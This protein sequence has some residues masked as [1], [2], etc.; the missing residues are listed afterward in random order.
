MIAPPEEV[1][2]L[3]SW[4]EL[5]HLSAGNLNDELIGAQDAIYRI[6]AEQHVCNLD[7]AL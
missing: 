5:Q 6:P 2:H 1:P 7:K 3:L 4:L